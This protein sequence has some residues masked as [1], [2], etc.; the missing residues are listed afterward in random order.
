MYNAGITEEKRHSIWYHHDNAP[1]ND[2]ERANNFLN[3]LFGERW[4]GRSGLIL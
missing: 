3:I 1:M 4:I 2:S